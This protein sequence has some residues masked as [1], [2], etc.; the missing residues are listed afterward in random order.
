MILDKILFLLIIF[1]KIFL[2]P[3]SQSTDFEVHRN[4]KSIT[5]TLPISE[6][7]FYSDNKWTLDYP[8][9]FAYME[10]VLGKISKFFDS[11]ITNITKFNYDS[12]KCIIF[13]RTTVLLGDVFLFFS[14]NFLCKA[15]NLPFIKYFIL[16]FSIQFYAGLVII[17]NMHFQYNGILFGLLLISIGFIAKKKY[18][19]GAIFYFV[20]LCMKHIF[21]YFAP[22]YFLFYL[23]YIIINNI[24]K[25]RFKFLIKKVILIGLSFCII[26]IITFLP[27]IAISIRDKN[28]DQFIQ[29][30]NRL[31]PV[32]RGLL[33]TYWAPNFWA[34]YSFIDKIFYFSYTKKFPFLKDICSI[35][36]KYK[37]NNNINEKRNISS[38]GSTENGVSKE[39]G[40]DIL[41]DID[42]KKTNIIIIIFILIYFIKYFYFEKK[43]N[44]KE[45]IKNNK[46]KEF[47]KHCICFN[48]IFFN[49]GYQVHEKAF[50]NI[51]I[52]SI[53]YYIITVHKEIKIIKKDKEELKEKK[54][55]SDIL[56]KLSLMIVIEG[57]VAQLPLIHEA[58]DYL[59]KVG[60]TLFYIFVSKAIL[61]NK[62][63][64]SIIMAFINFRIISYVILSLVLDFLI[65]F[66]KHFNIDSNLFLMKILNYIKNRYSFLYLLLFSINGAILTQIIFIILLIY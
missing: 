24:K 54:Y 12:I 32:Q 16:L 50:L 57:I 66:Q 30:K 25:K 58:K 2:F 44:K 8:P 13:L 49:F 40:F 47:I 38:L 46:I 41:P 48:L 55:F 53:I 29:I 33:H 56:T 52:L 28:L 59:V 1:L 60:I 64:N 21:I 39:T 36:L 27:F 62:N 17:D 5:N 10:Y 19:F 3:T 65:T 37:G 42:I 61:F 43:K 63:N 11:N 45:K 15:L 34:L 9:L 23:K 6:W 26:L 22:A 7:Y 35:L 51:S 4:W 14:I 31:F 18:I 20:C